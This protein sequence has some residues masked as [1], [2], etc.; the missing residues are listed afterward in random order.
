MKILIP[1]FS[2]CLLLSSVNGAELVLFS[3]SHKTE[4]SVKSWKDLRDEHIVKQ[5]LD[6]SCGAASTA[7]I[8]N[9]FYGLDVTEKKLLDLMEDDGVYSFQDLSEVVTNYGMKGVGL[10]LGFEEIKKLKIPVIAYMKYRDNDHFTVIRGVSE[11]GSVLLGDPSWGNRKFTKHQFLSMWETR[12]D[13][14]LKGKILLLL[15]EN[16]DTTTINRDFFGLTDSA[17][18][19]IELLTTGRL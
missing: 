16:A 8:L 11:N 17:N 4:I 5:D 19:A 3:T 15:P 12:D 10:A 2:I 14:L 9:G 6:Y 18:L 13:D 1:L 7:T